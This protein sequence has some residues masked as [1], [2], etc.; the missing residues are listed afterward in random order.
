M[1]R[2]SDP[3]TWGGTLP[4]AGARVVIPA[5]KAVLLDVATPALAG[6]VVE[7]ALR[8]DP[9]R[10]V[11]ITAGHVYVKG[12]RL[13]IGTADEPYLK[14]ATIT[15]TGSTTADA[16]GMAGFG[17]KV[18]GQ[19]GGVLEM[20]GA[21]LARS[22][23]R[24]DGGDVAAG[25]RRIT[26]AETPGWRVGDRIV[27]A[28]SSFEQGEYDVGEIA[29]VD[30][31]SLELKQP[32]KYRHFGATRMVGTTAIDVRAEVG[33]LTRN[34][35]VQGDDNSEALKIGG[36]AMFMAASTAGSGAMAGTVQIAGV[37]FTRMGQLDKLG[38]YP[39]HFHLM[40]G[41]CVACYVRDASVHSS[42]QRG[43]VV[44]GT[45]GVT[46]AGNV[47]FNIVGHNI[48]VEDPAASGNLLERNLALVNRQ[49]N[50]LHTEPTLKSQED[51]MPSNYW[52]RA[53][54]NAVVGNHAAGS[55]FNGFNYVGIDEHED[56]RVGLPIDFRNNTAHAAMGREGVA[57]GDFDITGALLV[58]SQAP[59]P[60]TDR[61]EGFLGYHSA[62]GIWLEESGVTKV[63]RFTVAENATNLFGRGVGNRMHFKGGL[64]VGAL[65][66]SGTRPGLALHYTY[67]S[68]TLIEDTTFAAFG[69][70][71]FSGGDT[72][73]PQASVTMRGI[74]FIGARPSIDFGD[75]LTYEALD[76]TLLPRGWYVAPAARW[77]VTSACSLKVLNSRDPEVSTFTHG[78]RRYGNAELHVRTGG[79]VGTTVAN[80][81]LVRSDGLRYR[82]GDND[83]DA[84]RGSGVHA[85]TVVTDAGLS[86]VL[87]QP[88]TA[89]ATAMRLDYD[90][91]EA[92]V[93]LA[94]AVAVSAAVP[95]AGAPRA[96]HRTSGWAAQ[97]E[98]P[99]ATSALRPAASMAEFEA[100]P[101]TTYFHD[102]V[103]QRVWVKAN[104][105]WVIVQP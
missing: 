41:N 68:D 79:T 7:G 86:Y 11:A 63:E 49:P 12:G 76:D 78:P 16:A 65:P 29:A 70:L 17:N 13:T 2:W 96:V 30:G 47:V 66:G 103:A 46:V 91:H 60:A 37:E 8:A 42:I 93:P 36:H 77:M 31:R 18:L 84:E 38:R 14:R 24:L 40:A 104:R 56:G 81:W 45:S 52:M 3:A 88:P 67:G 99:T 33:L 61:M 53:S 55:F 57:P 62:F 100:N 83:S 51:R 85:A 23:T 95:L 105:R 58:S 9:A 39:V 72:S 101:L 97:P 75:L 94:D 59:R 34:I 87:E 10:D 43:I 98:A 22:W 89:G 69:A 80:P 5:G 82:Q 21:P 90:R 50:P 1:Q 48:V 44:H 64:V 32:L 4:P 19:M 74:S 27:I 35:V 25:A 28:T 54:T 6:L 71:N 15:L 92:Q 20:H 102:A 26:L 73:P